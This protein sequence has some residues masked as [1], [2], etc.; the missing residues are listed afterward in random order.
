MSMVYYSAKDAF[1]SILEETRERVEND[2]VIYGPGN[3]TLRIITDERGERPVCSPDGPIRESEVEIGQTG[4]DGVY[5]G[6]SYTVGGSMPYPDMLE[7]ATRDDLYLFAS[8]ANPRVLNYETVKEAF[9]TRL[10]S[11]QKSERI[12]DIVSHKSNE[13]LSQV[14]SSETEHFDEFF[15]LIEGAVQGSRF[16]T[17]YPKGHIET[18]PVQLDE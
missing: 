13:D 12:E 4:R 9:Y 8:L 10:E 1:S 17:F 11:I 15:G 6:R 16:D 3:C 5:H 7:N 18:P 14:H 2:K